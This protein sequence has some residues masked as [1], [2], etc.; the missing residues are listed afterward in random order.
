MD[1]VTIKGSDDGIWTRDMLG[2]K[3]YNLLQLCKT[4]V[5]IPQG[6][7]FPTELCREY[8]ADGKKISSKLREKIISGIR[9]LE[10][11][12]QKHFGDAKAPLII[13]VRSGAPV[14]MPGM[15]ET[16]LNAGINEQVLSHCNQ[17]HLYYAYLRFI[18]SYA[19]AV[20]HVELEEFDDIGIPNKEELGN[21]IRQWKQQYKM[22]TGEDFC[23]DVVEYIVNCVAAVFDS[24]NNDNAVRYREYKQIPHDLYTA[25][26]LQEMVFGN[27]N[28]ASGTGVIFTQN[29]LTGKKELY[30][31]YLPCA[32]GEDIVSGMSNPISIENLKETQPVIYH[33]LQT[34]ADKIEKQFRHPQDIEFT[35]E[36]ETLYILQTRNMQIKNK[37]T[38][39]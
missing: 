8:Y 27:Y 2:N 19:R 11:D 21:R 20:K 25:V 28:A 4:D 12:T 14:S 29:P 9:A 15:M 39:M 5:K 6:I 23:G 38:K 1:F 36:N 37:Q 22:K 17:L 30:G 31:E 32:Q 33:G 7:I 35:Y 13:S 3:G 26:I 18:K 24:W 16:I 10:A 34:A